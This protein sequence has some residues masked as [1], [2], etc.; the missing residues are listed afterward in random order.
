M[1]ISKRLLA[2]LLALAMCFALGACGSATEE[3][4]A[5][6]SAAPSESESADS[7]TSEDTAIEVDLTQTMFEF[8]SGLNDEDTAV[9][10][11][12]V[13]IPN[14]QFFYWL[15]YYCSYMDYTYY[16]YGVY[17]DFADEN[18]R[19]TMLDNAKTAVV[20]YA[21]L[22]ELCQEA[23][24]TVTEE[25]KEDYQTSLDA[26]VAA[27]YSGNYDLLYQSYGMS[28]ESLDY[29]FYNDYLYANYANTVIPEP[30]EEELAQYVEDNGIFAVKH[31]LL[32]TATQNEDGTLALLDG[33]A[34]V[35][36]DGS[37]YTGTAEEYNAAQLALAQSLLA[38][39]QDP[40]ASD[41]L[42]DELMV[43]YS[44]DGGVTAYPD[45]Y[46]FTATDSLVDGFR[47][48]TL[49]L[50]EGGLSDIVETAYGYHIML[51]LPVDTSEYRDTL[52]SSSLN[53]AV[54]ARIETA[55][56]VVSDDITNL[57]VENFYVRYANYYSQLY[58]ELVA[59]LE[60]ES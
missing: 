48:A 5:S 26:T 53:D 42:F 60:S 9:T 14:E 18:L 10:V 29:L 1:T 12:G 24:V 27:S 11:N 40:S 32:M 22:N 54:T 33:S 16:Q 52:V 50:E 15:S 8:S 20:S 25:Q 43:A 19:V 34:P 30:T 13:A 45:G 57:D 36:E 7:E 39:L 37:E 4:S 51:R 6:D 23:G 2:L 46:T 55:E 59:M 31:I 47:E 35:N 58:S 41:T 28:R 21:I 49:A 17:V 56:V 3:P 44:E 38:Q